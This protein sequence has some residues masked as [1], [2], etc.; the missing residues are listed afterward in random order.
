MALVMLER[1][2][3]IGILKAV[4]YASRSVL[5]EVLVEQGTIGFA[6]RLLVLTLLALA[7]VAIAIPV[8]TTAFSLPFSVPAP[9]ILGLVTG[10]VLACMAVAASVAWRATRVRP[11]EVLHYE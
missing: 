9:T 8:R 11:L 6:G 2:R 1:R 3:E 7:L 10:A 5:G 4:G